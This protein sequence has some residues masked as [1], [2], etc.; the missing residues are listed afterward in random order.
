MTTSQAAYNTE[1][2]GNNR[3]NPL[4]RD[5]TQGGPRV[6]D[7]SS[8]IVLMSNLL[9]QNSKSLIL[10]QS[11]AKVYVDSLRLPEAASTNY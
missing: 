2:I 6:G 5:V 4:S 3:R 8:Q 1:R 11:T 7:T 9:P 10:S